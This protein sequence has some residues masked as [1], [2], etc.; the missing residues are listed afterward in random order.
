MWGK[1][2]SKLWSD[3]SHSRL[4]IKWSVLIKHVCFMFSGFPVV[5]KHI[6]TSNLVRTLIVIM[7]SLVS[8]T[9]PPALLSI[10]VFYP[11]SLTSLSAGVP[12]P[13]K[14]PFL[15]G[16][17][18]NL[19]GLQALRTGFGHLNPWTFKGWIFKLQSCGSSLCPRTHTQ[20]LGL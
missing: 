6:F 2:I 1:D 8:W 3:L 7:L 13:L 15:P 5:W 11:T 20:T 10:Q 14:E 18:Q 4:F 16:R 12:L 17:T 19:A 9:S